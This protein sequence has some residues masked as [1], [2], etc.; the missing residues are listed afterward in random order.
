MLLCL[1]TPLNSTA[2]DDGGEIFAVEAVTLGSGLTG[3]ARGA[4][5]QYKSCRLIAVAVHGG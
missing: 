3:G 5:I 2:A 4:K 1:L